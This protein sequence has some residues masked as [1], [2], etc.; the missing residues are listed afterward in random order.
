VSGSP[1]IAR[2]KWFNISRGFGFVVLEDDKVDAFLHVTALQRA[3]VNSLG[4]GACLLCHIER[5][6]DGAQVTEVIEVL[7]PGIQTEPVRRESSDRGSRHD[8]ALSQM[9][10]TVKSYD[11]ERGFGFVIAG[12]GQKD[13]FLHRRC[14]KRHGLQTL[15]PG[16][17]IIMNVRLTP[18]GPEVV[19]FEFLDE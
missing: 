18:R 9:A 19:D 2:L 16:A 13:I 11:A 8:G 7:D 3:G 15:E 4:E 10:G 1:V 6:Q 12:Y 14:L 5:G 17:R